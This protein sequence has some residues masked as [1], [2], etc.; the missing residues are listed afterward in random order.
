MS[1]SLAV[2]LL[3]RFHADS[4]PAVELLVASLGNEVPRTRSPVEMFRFRGA[5]REPVRLPPSTFLLRTSVEY[6]NP[7]LTLEELQGILLARLLEVS[8]RYARAQ[9]SRRP[10]PE[11]LPALAGWLAEPPRGEVV[12]FV[13]NV[14]DIEA[15]RYSIN[16]LRSSI[17][18][19]GQS[20]RAVADVRCA[21]LAMDP[22]FVDRYRGKLVSE[23]DVREIGEELSGVGDGSYLDLVD[24]VKYRQLDAYTDLLG[25]DLG[26]PAL[27]M[28][29]TTLREE[30][31]SGPLHRLISAAH[32]DVPT[33]RTLYGMFGREFGRR[34]TLLPAVPHAPDGAASKRL[35]RGKVVVDIDRLS[36]VEVR[37]GSGPLYPNEI[38]KGDTARGVADT[39]FEVD[40]G[41]LQSYDFRTTPAS[42]Q[43]ALYMLASP[44]DGALWHG[45]G[46]YAG[47]QIVESYTT[48]HRACADGAPFLG[49]PL[50]CRSDP[51]QWDLVADG[52]L[53]H[54]KWGNI[55]ASAHCVEDVAK[56]LPLH[57]RLRPVQLPLKE[58]PPGGESA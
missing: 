11:D 15:D 16:P 12:P 6:A 56:L 26:I 46:K 17:M 47:V 13:L 48:F 27:R 2:E 32:R 14:D 22:A 25:I 19:S 10:S 36:K 3:E 7:Q 18:E 28:P 24:R 29:L 54:P 50:T 38:D 37:Y 39:E 43:F 33:L 9:S 34:K 20:A 49:V 23:R 31:T 58:I 44:E 52:M 21:G 57:T 41:R 8:A 35:V 42:P 4:W 1:G 40:P 51:P 45:L 5:R 55:D 53:S 30:T